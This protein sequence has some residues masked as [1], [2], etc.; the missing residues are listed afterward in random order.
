MKSSS[1]SASYSGAEEPGYVALSAR[2]EPA[3]VMLTGPESAILSIKNLKTKPI[4]LSKANE[5][6]KKKMPVDLKGLNITSEPAIVTVFVFVE[7]RQI[8][9]IIKNI[10]VELKNAKLNASVSPLKIMLTIKGGHD[11]LNRKDIKEKIK[12]SIDIKGLKPGIYVRRAV[13]DL[14]LELIMTDAQPEI[15]TVKIE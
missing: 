1:I 3:K 13:I 11:M 5:S 12:V 10:P 6:F 9:K 8:I 15:F 4:D 2:I 7:K 14:P